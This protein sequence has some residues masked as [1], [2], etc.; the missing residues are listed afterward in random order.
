MTMRYLS[1]EN[2]KQYKTLTSLYLDSKI[3]NTMNH[4]ALCMS[5]HFITERFSFSLFVRLGH[6]DG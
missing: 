4:Y 5:Y 6:H 3:S 2:K 1:L